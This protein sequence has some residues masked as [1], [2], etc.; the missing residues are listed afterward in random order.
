MTWLSKLLKSM[1]RLPGPDPLRPV[2]P[3]VSPDPEA[4]A[5]LQRKREALTYYPT[6]PFHRDM[7]QT[8]GAR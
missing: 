5:A 4:V 3:R 8:R 6:H 1:R 2:S 7:I